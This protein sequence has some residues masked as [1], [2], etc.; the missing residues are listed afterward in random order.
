MSTPMS[1]LKSL[2]LACSFLLITLVPEIACAQNETARD[3]STFTFYQENDIYAGTDRG[4]TN[5]IKFSWVS[6]DLTDYRQ[7]PHVPK[8]SYPLIDALPFVN[9]PGFQRNVSLSIGQNM[10][11]PEDVEEEELIEGD[12][13]YAGLSYL[14]IAF[15]SRNSSRMDTLEFDIGIVGPH[16]YAEKSQKAVH[17]WTNSNYP[18]GWDNQIKDEPFLNIYYERKVKLLRSTNAGGIGYDLIPHAGCAVGNAYTA[19]NAGAQVR[20]GWNLPNDFGT[21]FIRPGSDTN[22]PY[23]EQDPRFYP[24]HRQFGIHAFAAVDGSAVLRNIMLDGN[25]YRESYYVDKEP[26]VGRLLLGIGTI[27]HR[28]K[29]TYAYVFITK[30]F[31]TQDAPQ[32][33]GTITVSYTF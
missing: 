31:E 24:E 25:L 21:S 32:A 10:Y 11:T 4:Y 9:E 26:F 8:W 33:Y 23:D 18:Q 20:W 2:I 29:I 17:K 14:G 1:A 27:I 5:G 16:S 15:I 22:A 3:A 28:F 12:R 30:E 6:A 7:N 19:A 13:P